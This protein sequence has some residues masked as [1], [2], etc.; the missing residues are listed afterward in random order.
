MTRCY[1]QYGGERIRPR[2]RVLD[3]HYIAT[4]GVRDAAANDAE[5][6]DPGEPRAAF[7]A[8][9]SF[10]PRFRLEVR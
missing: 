10:K 7:V 4:V 1:V 8:D 3:A 5:I 2:F 6:L 9:R